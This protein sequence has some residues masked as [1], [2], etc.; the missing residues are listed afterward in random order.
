VAL[1]LDTAKN[2]PTGTWPLLAREFE[3]IG[4]MIGAL[5]LHTLVVQE[6]GYNNRSLGVNARHF[7]AGL[8]S[9]AFSYV[10]SE[11]RALAASS[12]LPGLAP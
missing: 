7:F 6:G 3:Q 8:W 12:I 5:R 9:G 11:G 2:D 4:N 1:G 10:P